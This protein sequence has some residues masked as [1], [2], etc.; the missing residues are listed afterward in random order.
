MDRQTRAFA[1]NYLVRPP[2]LVIGSFV[3]AVYWLLYGWW[4]EKLY[5]AKAQKS[6]TQEITSE[7]SFLFEAHK[8]KVIPNDGLET[9]MLAG[10][11]FIT[12][13]VEGLLLRFV[14]W[15]DTRQVHIASERLP[16]EWQD[17]SRVLNIMD[18]EN[19]NSHLIV[20]FQDGRTTS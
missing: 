13:S 19:S 6:L 3:R 1:H 5:L 2:I 17:L 12:I 18:P 8:A 16:R 7:F 11:P 10:W 4:G 15:R 14:P 20:T 9:R